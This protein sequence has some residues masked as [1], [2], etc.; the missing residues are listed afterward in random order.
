MFINEPHQDPEEE[1]KEMH[2]HDALHEDNKKH[3]REMEAHENP[4]P[5]NNGDKN[6]SHHGIGGK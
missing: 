3:E 6:P 1:I 4:N 5:H 2:D